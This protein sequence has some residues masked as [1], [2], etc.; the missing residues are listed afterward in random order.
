VAHAKHPSSTSAS[1]RRSP[2]R[3]GIVWGSFLAAATAVSGVLALGD[4]R[5]LVGIPAATLTTIRPGTGGDDVADPI[6]T[7]E[8]P[9]QAGRWT[10]IVVHHS[11][12]PAGDADA[13]ARQ[14]VSAGHLGLGYH[15]II[16]NGNGMG[17][18]D[19]HVGFRWLQ[20][21]PGA[22]TSG[23]RGK[24]LNERAIGIC[25]VGNGDRRA[26]TDAQI[27]QLARL[28]RRLQQQFDIPASAVVLHSDVAPGVTSPGALFPAARLQENLIR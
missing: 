6:I 13:I 14:H 28:V 12:A 17:D 3:V 4:G 8:Q 27:D 7:T 11:G 15:F 25:L 24:Q 19:L 26:F 10:G 9:L 18:G 1:R 20:Q 22:H 21:L 23:P 5:D 16:G 2:R